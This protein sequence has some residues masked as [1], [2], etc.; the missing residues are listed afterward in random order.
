[1]RTALRWI[2]YHAARYLL[3]CMIG[4]IMFIAILMLWA[5]LIVGFATTT[6]TAVLGGVLTLLIPASLATLALVRHLRETWPE[7]A[8]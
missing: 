2:A 7:I 1:M 3:G 8:A 5:H 4:A 6:E